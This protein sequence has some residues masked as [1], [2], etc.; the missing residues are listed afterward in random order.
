[1][2][3]LLEPLVALALHRAQRLL[4]L[5]RVRNLLLDPVAL[6]RRALHPLL[7]LRALRAQLVEPGRASQPKTLIFGA[8]SGELSVHAAEAAL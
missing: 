4:L 7:H 5:L 2:A 8:A 3:S 1:M 6:L